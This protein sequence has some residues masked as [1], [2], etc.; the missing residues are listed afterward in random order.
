[1]KIS[2]V[3]LVC[4]ILAATSFKS[5][6]KLQTINEDRFEPGYVYTSSDTLSVY[7]RLQA[8]FDLGVEYKT[9][10]DSKDILTIRSQ[11]VISI[12]V[13]NRQFNR[14][15]FAGKS[16]LAEVIESGLVTLYKHTEVSYSTHHVYNKEAG[17]FLPTKGYATTTKFYISKNNEVHKLGELL[18]YK[19]NLR[20]LMAD[21]EQ[22]APL[23]KQL[24]FRYLEITLDKVIRKYNQL[25]QSSIQHKVVS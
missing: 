10:P 1:M 5:Y 25:N 16:F 4:L 23:I 11:D 13:T 19:R 15:K 21:Q 18:E 14:L 17:A 7:I 22:I 20:K 12:R 3:L 24:R 2:Q 8:N 9:H 6:A